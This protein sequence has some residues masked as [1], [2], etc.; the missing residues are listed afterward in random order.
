MRCVSCQQEIPIAE[1]QS[2]LEFTFGMARKPHMKVTELERDAIRAA[3]RVLHPQFALN[4]HGAGAEGVDQPYPG[5]YPGIEFTEQ[6]PDVPHPL[7]NETQADLYFCSTP[8]LRNWFNTTVDALETMLER[9][10]VE[11]QL[12]NPA[13]YGQS[14]K[15]KAESGA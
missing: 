7:M 5:I 3:S 9:G 1:S 13:L 4:W 6:H 14:G 8:C 11:G 12:T 2:Y 15:Q 10:E